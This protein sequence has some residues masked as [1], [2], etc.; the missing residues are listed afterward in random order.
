MDLFN[1][2]N[3]FRLRSAD[4][5]S[6][7]EAAYTLAKTGELDAVEILREELLSG[8]W[9]ALKILE[10][11]GHKPQNAF[12]RAL[13]QIYQG[14]FKQALEEG[15]AAVKALHVSLLWPSG[16]RE[17]KL[18]AIQALAQIGA[19]EELIHYLNLLGKN[20]ALVEFRME[21]CRKLGELGDARAV[22]ALLSELEVEL[23]A[24]PSAADSAPSSAFLSQRRAAWALGEIGD[25]RALSGLMKAALRVSDA[26]LDAVEALRK[27]AGPRKA[28]EALAGLLLQ[29]T[30]VEGNP[31]VVVL[32]VKTLCDGIPGP[33][34]YALGSFA[35]AVMESAQALRQASYETL[36][37]CLPPERL[38]QILSC[39]DDT[40]AMLADIL[41]MDHALGYIPVVHAYERLAVMLLVTIH[42]A[43]ATEA[44]K[45]I[46]LDSAAKAELKKLAAH[47]LGSRLF[48][49]A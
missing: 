17:H 22:G 24:I 35:F 16:S 27:I 45:R 8:N 39:G 30:E 37:V 4:R 6:R 29:S 23:Q 38:R 7:V 46:A 9:Q 1:H 32:A 11:T 20:V 47:V 19:V 41:E 25:A 14:R 49:A 33:Y 36:V 28:V 13:F 42:D 15:P 21:V 26:S 31:E 10:E 44:L 48:A 34:E 12:E 18:S 43:K 40:I 3:R 5:L 2:L